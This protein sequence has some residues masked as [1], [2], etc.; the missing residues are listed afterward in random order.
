MADEGVCEESSEIWSTD[1]LLL[2]Q[3]RQ[4]ALLL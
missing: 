3:G 4:L 1:G 2:A